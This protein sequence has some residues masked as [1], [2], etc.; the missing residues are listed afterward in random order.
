VQKQFTLLS[1]FKQQTFL[2]IIF[3]WENIYDGEI[4]LRYFFSYRYRYLQK[5]DISMTTNQQMA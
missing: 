1:L 3:F 2:Y 4:K 5:E